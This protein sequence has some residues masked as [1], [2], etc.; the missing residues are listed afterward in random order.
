AAHIGMARE[1]LDGV[2]TFYNLIFRKPVG[3]HVIY[4][5]DSVS[6]WILNVDSIKESISSRLGIDYGET[7][8]DGLF[9]ML[10]IQC[11]GTCDHAPALMID[12]DLYRDLDPGKIDAILDRYKNNK[13]S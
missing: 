13:R 4:V 7:T 1:Q 2:A 5:C 10:P 11:L 12:G 8:V 9:T 6:C 3:R